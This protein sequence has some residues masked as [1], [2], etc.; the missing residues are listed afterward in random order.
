MKQNDLYARILRALRPGPMSTGELEGELEERAQK[1]RDCCCELVRGHKVERT[2][3]VNPWATKKLL[4][5][6][7]HKAVVTGPIWPSCKKLR[8]RLRFFWPKIKAWQLA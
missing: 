5:C 2:T 1:I 3:K 4:F 8:H 6:I 7:E